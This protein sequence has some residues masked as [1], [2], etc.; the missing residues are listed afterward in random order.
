VIEEPIRRRYE[1]K[2]RQRYKIKRDYKVIPYKK[3]GIP[4]QTV[5]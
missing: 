1:K 3:I 2:D 4:L 5:A